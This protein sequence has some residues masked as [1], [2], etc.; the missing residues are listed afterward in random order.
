MRGV[1]RQKRA[2]ASIRAGDQVVGRPTGDAQQL[3]RDTRSDAFGDQPLGIDRL[4][5][6]VELLIADAET[7]QLAAVQLD[8]VARDPASIHEKVERRLPLVVIRP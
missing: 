4:G 3:E 7:P 6:F 5:M 8:E 1:A 2:T